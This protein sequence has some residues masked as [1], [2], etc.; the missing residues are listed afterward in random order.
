MDLTEVERRDG[1]IYFRAPAHHHI[2]AVHPAPKGFAIRRMTFDAANHDIV[3]ALHKEVAEA[4]CQSDGAA[5]ALPGPG[6]GYGF[7]FPIRKDATSRWSATLPTTRT[8]PAAGP[9]AQD[10]ARQSQRGRFGTSDDFLIDVLG[11][12]KVDHSGPWTSTIAT[13]RTTR[14]L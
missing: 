5:R 12:R 3:H 8:P 2:L 7:G 10:R 13:S 6:G 9:A 4:G 11:S 14:R 1:S